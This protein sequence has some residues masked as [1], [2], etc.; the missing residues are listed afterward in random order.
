M[1]YKTPG[2]YIEERSTLPPSVVG[3]E[4]AIP[5]FIGYTEKAIDRQQQSILNIPT[6]ITSMLEYERFFGKPA[7]EINTIVT[8]NVQ[9]N[10]LVSTQVDVANASNFIMHY[11][12]QFYFEN[13]G[14]DCYIV[15]VGDYSG[16]VLKD[17]IDD[18]L[19]AAG[20]VDEITLNVFP[21]AQALSDVDF[22]DLH[23]ASLDQCEDLQDRF[24]IMDT[25][26]D[27]TLVDPGDFQNITT[28]RGSGLGAAERTLKYGAAYYPNL[29]TSL[30][31]YFGEESDRDD[32]VQIAGDA[33]LA[34]TLGEL[35]SKNNVIYFQ[36][37]NALTQQPL[38]LPPSPAIA[39]IYVQ[40]DN[41]RGVWKAPANVNIDRVIRPTFRISDKAQENLNIDV[42]AGKSVNAIRTF[43]G[44]GPAI[45]WGART[46][47]GNSNEWRYVPVRRFFNFVEESVKN[48]TIPFVF[49]PNDINTWLRVKAMI[50][51][52]L[53][54]QWKAGALQGTTPEE[55]FRVRVGLGQTMSEQD[56]L[57]GRMI[58]EIGMAVVRPAEFIILRFEHKMLSE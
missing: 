30:D 25:W 9:N 50:E 44:R 4:T 48:A 8:L 1:E 52:F 16:I 14:S 43:T 35:K 49:E 46:L 31:Y 17:N 37:I 2:V 56:I 34:G 26:I 58:V 19:I 33:S 13:G 29:I 10:V 3:V 23:K 42:D 40:V 28:L 7:A 24:T 5:V 27:R 22:Y 41:A 18:G 38:E 36:V 45:I 6:K 55:A 32:S 12:L 47:A 39:G 54:Q 51:N 11:S 21:E 57:E 15:S 20:T 53:V